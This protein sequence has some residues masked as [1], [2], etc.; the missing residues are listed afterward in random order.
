M[1][2]FL[3]SADVDPSTLTDEELARAAAFAQN[4]KRLKLA[5]LV[6]VSVV[7][8]YALNSAVQKAQD[9]DV[10]I[11]IEDTSDSNE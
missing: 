8:G 10:S 2:K 7:A 9:V 5:G 1:S 3:R 11:E 4:L 6:V